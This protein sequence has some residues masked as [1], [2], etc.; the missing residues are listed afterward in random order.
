LRGCLSRDEKACRL[1]D[2]YASASA[3]IEGAG[4]GDAVCKSHL[5]L[6]IAKSGFVRRGHCALKHNTHR[7]QACSDSLT[8]APYENKKGT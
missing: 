4:E 2:I 7:E 5:P 1:N 8:Q 3:C 6:A